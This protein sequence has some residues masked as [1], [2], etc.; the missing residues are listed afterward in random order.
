MDLTEYFQLIS[1]LNILNIPEEIA[2]KDQQRF[3][4]KTLLNQK[5]NTLPAQ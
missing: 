4:N 1:Y 2:M 3:K 5:W